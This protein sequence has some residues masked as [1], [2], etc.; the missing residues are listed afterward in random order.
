MK[1]QTFEDYR[2][3]VLAVLV[4]VQRELDADLS[5]EELASVASFSPFH[6][7]RIFRGLVGES[8]K[9]HV[10][11]LRLERAAHRL[12]HTRQTVSEIAL[13]AGFQ[14]PESFTRAF[15][16]MFRRAPRDFRARRLSTFASSASTVHYAPDGT[17]VD[18]RSPSRRPPRLAVRFERMP[19]K[20]V[21]FARHLGP[22]EN[23]DE[24]VGRLLGWAHRRGLSEQDAPLFGIAYDD[25]EV[26]PPDKLRYDAAL[27][28]PDTIGPE[29]NIGIQILPRRTYA[30]TLHRGP[31][32]TMGET[33]ARF[34]GEWLPMSGHDVLAA[35]AL[36]FYLNSPHETRPQ[37]LRTE[38]YLP[39][40]A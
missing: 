4:H 37:E 11:R 38:I 25:P 40:A 31:Y 34:C 21:A 5:L 1:Q 8:V 35:P 15:Q 9:E 12:R 18:F 6:F 10:R 14:S 30:V 24:A 17:L 23:A 39:V 20:R 33:Y 28:V 26:T 2:K 27:E 7:H 3:R 29:G 22:Y 36:E 32:E 13:D 16:K 19:E